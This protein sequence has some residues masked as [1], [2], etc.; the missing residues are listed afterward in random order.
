MRRRHYTLA[1]SCAGT[2]EA[3]FTV[4]NDD[5]EEMR[6][7]DCDGSAVQQSGEKAS[8]RFEIDIA[9][10]PGSSGMVAWTLLRDDTPVLSSP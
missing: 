2:G 1:V 6:R 8:S 10:R 5:R 3:T 7:F 4:K 9:G